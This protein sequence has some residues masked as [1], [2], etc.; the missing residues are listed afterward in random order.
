MT[1][2]T[3]KSFFHNESAQGIVEYALILALIALAVVT[4][5]GFL[6]EGLSSFFDHVTGELDSI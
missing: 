3:V 1:I 2:R 4:A 5:L 6:G